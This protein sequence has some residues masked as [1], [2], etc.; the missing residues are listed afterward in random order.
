MTVGT[1]ECGTTWNDAPS[2]L[3]ASDLAHCTVRHSVIISR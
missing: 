3:L 2:E 1:Q